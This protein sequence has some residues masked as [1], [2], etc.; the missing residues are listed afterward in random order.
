MAAGWPS[1]WTA[2]LR[3]A[4]SGDGDLFRLRDLSSEAGF[5]WMGRQVGGWVEFPSPADWRLPAAPTCQNEAPWSSAVAPCACTL[6]SGSHEKETR[7]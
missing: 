6:R 5:G 1:G 2:G 4:G 3:W 7:R